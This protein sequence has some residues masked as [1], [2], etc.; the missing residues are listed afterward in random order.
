MVK[1]VPQKALEL[2]D[3]LPERFRGYEWLKKA[4]V[5]FNVGKETALNYFELLEEFDLI[6]RNGWYL[7]KTGKREKA[8][9]K[10]NIMDVSKFREE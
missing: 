7:E 3:I 10:I 1:S 6:R 9:K 8:Q 4:C 5:L 2:Y